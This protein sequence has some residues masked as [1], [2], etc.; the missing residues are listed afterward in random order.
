MAGPGCKF[1]FSTKLSLPKFLAVRRSLSPRQ[2]K[3][4]NDIGQASLLDLCLDEIPRSL[5]VW[6]IRHFK[7][8]KNLVEF[9]DGSSFQLNS[10]CTHKV[11]GTPIGGRLIPN[12]C[13]DNFRLHIRERTKCGGQTP[14]INELTELLKSDLDDEDFQRYWMMFTVT[15]LLCPTTYDCVSPEFLSACEG[16]PEGISSYDWSSVIFRKLSSSID[17]FINNNFSGALCGCLLVPLVCSSSVFIGFVR[18]YH[19]GFKSSLT[20]YF[21]LFVCFCR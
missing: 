2:E 14:S 20:D 17:T 11:L 5:V 4:V 10:M 16:P 19:Y 3:L 7:P 8:R 13:S 1:E 21:V 18:H 15:V 12:K 9:P 6:I